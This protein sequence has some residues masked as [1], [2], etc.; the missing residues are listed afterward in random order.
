MVVIC[1]FLIIKFDVICCNLIGVVIKMLEEV[2]LCV[3]VLKC[4]QMIK[5]Q[6]EGFY[7]VYKECLF[8]NDFVFFMISGLV[9]V[10][11]FEGED[12]V[13]CNCDV[14][15]V[16]NFEQVDEGMICKVFVELIEVNLVY[17]LDL[18]ENVK[19]EIE[20]FFKFEELVG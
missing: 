19:I 9:V 17:G 18:D 13:K 2:G 4:I 1:I 11:V 6:V 3:I 15:G 7:V 20:Y 14:M 5:E 16:I 12:V 8:F 10:Q